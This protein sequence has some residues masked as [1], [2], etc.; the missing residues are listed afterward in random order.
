MGGGG[1][2]EDNK[3]KE[4][5]KQKDKKKRKVE[6]VR[7]KSSVILVHSMAAEKP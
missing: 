2:A 7:G 4:T 1:A 3:Q 5:N 6:S